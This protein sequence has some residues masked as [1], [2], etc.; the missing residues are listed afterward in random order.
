M[1]SA[2]VG[3][4]HESAAKALAAD[5]SREVR[6]VQVVVRDALPLFGWL[7]TRILRDLYR[8]QL[9]RAPWAYGLAYWLMTR[10]RPAREVGSACLVLAGSRR[11][12]RLVA[13]ERPDVVVSTYP[14][15]TLVLGHLRRRRR[16]A[17]V[18][19][20]ITDLAGLVYWAHPG[21]D[22]HLVMH[23][24]C[25]AEIERAAGRGSARR[26]R[27]LVAPAFFEAR[28]RSEARRKFGLPAD[29]RIVVVSGGGW[30]VGDLEGA[31]EAALAVP[32][33][34]VAVLAGRNEPT[35]WRL[36]SRF[37]GAERVV[38]IG[39]T[40][41]MADLLAAADAI[42]HTTG[43]VTC[44]EALVAGCPLV[45]YGEPPGHARAN[46]PFLSS[47]GLA[48]SARTPA[49]LQQVLERVLAGARAPGPRL[50][51][52]PS[53]A[54]VVASARARVELLPRWRQALPRA[55]VAL[56]AVLSLAGWTFASD[57]PYTA[58]A[59]TFG[60]RPLAAV[61]TQRPE[62]AL[63]LRVRTAL[64]PALARQ[65]RGYHA[66][67]SF[68]VSQSPGRRTRAAVA[69]A[70]DELTPELSGGDPTDWLAAKRRLRR[71]ARSLHLDSRFRYLAP[72][73]G[74]ALGEYL[75]VRADG[76]LPVVGA[77]RL[78]SGQAI[79][80]G[81]LRPGEVI[82]LTLDA[83]PVRTGWTLGRVLDE[84]EAD[85]LSAN[86]LSGV[87][88]DASRRPSSAGERSSTTVPATTA[89]SEA[90]R[91][92]AVGGA[93]GQCSPTSSGASS[94]GTSVSTAKTTG[95]TCVTGRCCSAL[96]SLST[97]TPAAIPVRPSQSRSDGQAPCES[98]S[99]N[100]FVAMLLQANARPAAHAPM[101][102]SP[103]RV[104][105]TRYGTNASA[106]RAASAGTSSSGL[107]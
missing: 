47:R 35:R 3:L 103:R 74:L 41:Q 97:P 68:A 94:T 26:V 80:Q 25:V 15:A 66:Q 40:D 73:S 4:G 62:V 21:V 49:E 85:G 29:K 28:S 36:E 107:A 54:A 6:G 39:F 106:A 7:L 2:A 43:G 10:V 5:L 55:G 33:A 90:T 57:D 69:A 34:S 59:A 45:V 99:E 61:R 83:S 22:V 19:A 16:I 96:I 1:L 11:F 82:V 93:D 63:V 38:V 42:V 67:A 88:A 75:L 31:V 87:L 30:G 81:S 58:I 102:P 60:F 71:S 101:R 70:G 27:P 20:T 17:T 78:R 44:L 104:A 48:A 8:W 91:T 18:C 84:V 95:A 79:A 32:G 77:V 89:A 72:P 65:L 56:A 9:R 86:S 23:E 105:V 52:A 12:L 92:A 76:G 98:A 100:S 24:A 51:P 50:T 64:I 53:A 13:T 37:A 46:D 14:A